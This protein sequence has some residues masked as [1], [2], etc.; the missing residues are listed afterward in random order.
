MK[1]PF[2]RQQ[3]RFISL[4][5]KLLITFSIVFTAIFAMVCLRSYRYSTEKAMERLR[6]DME[7]TLQGAAAGV[8]VEE[9]LELYAE[10]E[11]NSEQ[12]SDDPRFENQLNWLELVQSIEPRAWL[13][14]YIPGNQENT[15]RIGESVT[16]Y[17]VIFLVDLWA[18]REAEKA[19]KFLEPYVAS[20]WMAQSL[21]TGQLMQ[22]P[23]PYTDF[24]GNWISAYAPLFDS[25]GN[26]VAGIGIDVE[27]DYVRSVQQG[28]L[29]GTL[30]WFAIAYCLLFLL[31]YWLSGVLTSKLTHLTRSARL[32]GAGNY[33]IDV[34]FD[35]LSSFPDELDMLAEVFD[36]TIDQIRTREQLIRE[37]KQ[38]ED[39]MR[40]ALEEER[41][42]NELTSRFVSMV[43]H[44]L[45]TPLTVV[46]TS[47]ELLEHYSARL[48]E[49]KR[50]EYYQRIRGAIQNMAQL[51]DDV[52]VAGKAEAGKLD[53]EPLPID[54]PGYCR[55]LIE[56]I[57]ISIQS[58]HTLTFEWHGD[59][60]GAIMDPKLLRI[61]LSNL[62]FNAIK[63]SPAGST[64][65]IELFCL[66]L[67]AV[68]EIR[69]RGIGIPTDDQ[70]HL[71]K[72]F[73]RA[74][75]V[76]AIRGTGLGL[77]IVKHCVSHHHG[78]VT[79]VSQEGQGTTF[80]VKLPLKP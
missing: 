42:L 31:I 45:R 25:A 47:T 44:E 55:D 23:D 6:E 38:T 32:I 51:I 52:L 79:F 29:V 21:E 24:W 57:R 43:S 20:R 59:G 62:L 9:L 78:Q 74:R 3:G 77:A 36:A 17:E 28:I 60:E 39:E 11:P 7:F 18:E 66:D 19:A 14:T 80:V 75:N 12:F 70:L 5:V 37:V 22:R 56:E 54:L 72:S 61:I 64:V 76:G 68:F 8:D 73:H 48:S 58:N 69:D 53:F 27:M 65:E 50:T 4:R 10:G 67:M 26:L 41:E 49:E 35:R 1:L 40:H 46:R 13:Y 71:F 33:D 63:Y 34:E 15:R 30:R 2:A 16:G